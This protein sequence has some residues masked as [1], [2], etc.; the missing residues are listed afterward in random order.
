MARAKANYHLASGQKLL[1]THPT[2]KKDSHQTNQL[3]PRLKNGTEQKQISHL[4][5][6]R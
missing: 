2:F 3:Q 4:R 5:I 1:H 6:F